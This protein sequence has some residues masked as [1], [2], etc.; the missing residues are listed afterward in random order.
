MALNDC[1][2]YEYYLAPRP[3]ER[4]VEVE[5]LRALEQDCV[6]LL[7]DSLRDPRLRVRTIAARTLA[8]VGDERA[9][10]PLCDA[11]ESADR[12]VSPWARWLAACAGIVFTA[13]VTLFAVFATLVVARMSV[14][15]DSK[16]GLAADWKQ[17]M[18]T[19]R[20][21]ELFITAVIEAL[22]RIIERFP[23][24]AARRALTPLHRLAEDTV[25]HQHDTREQAK[26]VAHRINLSTLNCH[27]L[28]LPSEAS[29]VTVESLPLPAREG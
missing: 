15:G 28:P 18:A 8:E 17:N 12:G 2:W 21:H 7:C 9:V 11:L 26:R 27:R 10:G 4:L 3:G 1:S 25:R 29:P 5:R 20:G 14:S 16:E 6:P 22:D 19:F 23:S 24:P 13:L